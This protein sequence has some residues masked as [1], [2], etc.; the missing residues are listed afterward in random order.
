LP[1]FECWFFDISFPTIVPFQ[2]WYFENYHLRST[3]W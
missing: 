3:L 1:Y 2:C